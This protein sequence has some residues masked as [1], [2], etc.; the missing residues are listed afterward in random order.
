VSIG[1]SFPYQTPRAGQRELTELL[2]N[3]FEE[4]GTLVIDA[5]SG[6]GKTV[7]ILTAFNEI[8]R[9]DPSSKLILVTRTKRQITR[10]VEEYLKLNR[11]L[12]C[13]RPVALL[14]RFELCL[15]RQEENFSVERPL[16]SN[17][18][19][20][21]IESRAC[22][23]YLKVYSTPVQNLEVQRKDFL[24]I[25]N[26]MNKGRVLSVC[27]YEALAVLS[28]N[29][30][31]LLMT[32]PYFL[33]PSFKNFQNSLAKTVKKL[34]YVFDEAHSLSDAVNSSFLVVL[35][36][37]ILN[38]TI[39][40][41]ANF[42]SSRLIQQ[43]TQLTINLRSLGE[44]LSTRKCIAGESALTLL[45][46]DLRYD[47]SQILDEFKF[48]LLR[49]NMQKTSLHIPAAC[50]KFLEA[51]ERVLWLS[52]LGILQSTI[53]LNRA[54]RHVGSTAILLKPL[55]PPALN[56]RLNPI[57]SVAVV[58]L[59]AT[60]TA[61]ELFRRMSGFD[62]FLIYWKPTFPTPYLP[63]LLC[64]VDASLSS[65]LKERKQENL[66]EIA[67]RLNTFVNCV[68][69][70]VGVFFCS[71]AMLETTAPRLR[72]PSDVEVLKES[73][74]LSEHE[75]ERM[76]YAFKA[77]N[78]VKRVLLA[79]QNGRFSEGED[80]APGSVKGVVIVGLALPRPTKELLLTIRYL[81]RDMPSAYTRIFIQPA[82]RACLQ[83]IGRALRAPSDKISIYLIDSRFL[84]HK[85][86]RELPLWLT[87][88]FTIV[89]DIDEMTRLMSEFYRES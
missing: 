73:R 78:T 72:F 36:E 47:L 59:S 41:L 63:K 43:L 35:T 57:Q 50:T 12:S 19:R 5:P 64:F 27:P 23:Y 67:K 6:F 44:L 49:M 89:D 20:Y 13:L 31:L 45:F 33:S 71:Y 28:L 29:S 18:C 11:E 7:C 26:L 32:Y 82:I 34:C 42:G 4:G 48:F 70:N 66:E 65:R 10:V 24:S 14:P 21:M 69:G 54:S 58:F 1:T 80:F 17:Y 84:H 40:W 81:K 22:S 37:G 83:S 60:P 25:E 87:Q 56:L 88:R 77:Q 55:R 68:P 8:L 74:R 9:E 15:K 16:F 52:E 53:A 61:P 2:V 3:L 85:I 75:A 86:A 39:A 51:M 38:D 30:N 76:M 79:V 62:N 46:K